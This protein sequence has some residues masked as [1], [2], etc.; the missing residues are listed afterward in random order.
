MALVRAIK[1]RARTWN[2]EAEAGIQLLRSYNSRLA[3][4]LDRE[5]NFEQRVTET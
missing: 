4:A 3:Y 1:S 5:L 2:G